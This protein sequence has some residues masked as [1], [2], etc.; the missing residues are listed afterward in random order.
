MNTV[1]R[2]C[3]HYPMVVFVL[4]TAAVGLAFELSG[5]AGTTRWL[6]SAAALSI[7]A[8]QFKG[9][10]DSLRAGSFGID[11]LAV[12]AIVST[13]AVG[14]YWAALVVCLMLTGGEALEDY[15]SARAGAELTSLLES[16]PTSAFRLDEDGEAASVDISDVAI[17][18]RLLVRP[19]DTIP[20]DSRLESERAVLDESSLTGESLPVEHARGDLLLSGS[21]NGSTTIEITAVADAAGS[22]FQR[23]IALVD[24][25]RDSKAPF[26]RLAD[27]V[28]VPFTLIAF[29][30][31]GAAWAVSGDPMRFAQVLVVATPCPLIIAAPVAFMAGMSRAARGGMIVKNAGTLEQVS[32]VATVAFDKTGTLT[33]GVPQVSAVAAMA[34]MSEHDVLRLAASAEL[35]STH[36]LGEAIVAHARTIGDVPSPTAAEEIPAQ[37]VVAVVDGIEIRVGKRAFVA[38]PGLEIVP[39]SDAGHTTIWVGHDNRLIGRI[40]LSDPIRE[41][42]ADTLSA[43][44]D[45]GVT[46]AMLTGDAPETAH[47]VGETLGI[48]DVRAGLLPEDKV[49]AIT[50]MTK[51][52]VM[53]VGDGVNDAPV[54]AVS[55]VGVAM[56]ARGSTAAVESADVVVMQD[57]L[58]RIPRLI[59]L[60]QRTMRIAWQAILIGVGMSIV[61]MLIGA[62]GFMP[63]FVGAWMQELVDLACILWALLAARPSRQERELTERMLRTESTTAVE[64]VV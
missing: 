61:L 11:I 21:L 47:R 55:D 9:M 1:L 12:T 6:V 59:L 17:G 36:P 15:A 53:M 52:P 50:A 54:L 14:E 38:E 25:A 58:F 30:I 7:A 29:L 56:G 4:A 46:V 24:E 57:D 43:V 2:F 37:G 33:R 45:A 13:V 8:T 18:D 10:V 26:V 42:T 34:D 28:A 40:D 63:A 32:K 51:R 62:T 31:A 44:H 35:Y 5:P 23:I 39:Q 22:Q 41:E 64:S 48:D 3:R 60:G 49:S 16:A 27:R 20:V 19:H